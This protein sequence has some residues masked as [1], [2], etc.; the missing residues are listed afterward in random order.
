MMCRV[1]ICKCIARC[2]CLVRYAPYRSP[3]TLFL[4]YTCHMP[5]HSVAIIFKSPSCQQES[6]LC[7]AKGPKMLSKAIAGPRL[8]T[9]DGHTSTR[10]APWTGTA[11][12]SLQTAH[13]QS[14]RLEADRPLCSPDTL[15]VLVPTILWKPLRRQR[16]L[17]ICKGGLLHVLVISIVTGFPVTS[18]YGAGP[19]VVARLNIQLGKRCIVHELRMFI[20][21]VPA[22]ITTADLRSRSIYN[23]KLHWT[24]SSSTS[25]AGML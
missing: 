21:S 1:N 10:Q 19:K 23:C 6:R 18:H 2:H 20:Y 15:G 5:C 11:I 9:H 8:I 22:A 14:A 16:I 3:K 4:T 17:F 13:Q 12:A 7:S 24:S 25:K